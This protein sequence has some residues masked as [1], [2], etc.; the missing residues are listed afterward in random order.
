MKIL[1]IGPQGSGKSTQGKLLADYLRIP[2]IS[3]GDIF[4][5]KSLQDTEEGRQIKQILDKGLL[6]DDQTTRQLVTER[7]QRFDAQNG[8]ILDGYPRTSEQIGLF[9]IH[10]FKP[11]WIVYLKI[12]DEIAIERLIKRGRADDTLELIKTRLQLYQDKT[13][14]L[15]EALKGYG[16][17]VEINGQGS[18][19]EVQ[20]RMRE[21][22]NGQE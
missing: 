11:D 5:E 12:P 17:I 6:V 15:L 16:K 3:T 2:Y 14:A 13:A 19:E 9:N 8:Y 4:R 22:L 1:L 21:A 7:L 10:N 18:I 20:Q